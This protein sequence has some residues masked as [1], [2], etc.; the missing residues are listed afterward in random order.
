MNIRDIIKES[1]D[2][3]LNEYR[4][5]QRLPF[6][7]DKFKNKNYLE[8]YTDWL[9]DFGK[10]GKLSH[11]NLDFWDE[12]RKGVNYIYNHG[13]TDSISSYFEGKNEDELYEALVD[14]IFRSYVQFDE[15]GNVYVE[16]AIN[17]PNEPDDYDR[18]Y[19]DGEDPMDF[20]S[21]L[22][23]NYQN[24]V[25]GCWS[26]KNGAARAYCGKDTKNIIV[27]KGYIRTDDIDFIKTALLN[28]KYIDEFEIRVK[29]NAKV[30]VFEALY[31]YRYR[32][33][34]KGNLIVN[35]TYFGNK[36]TYYGE[37]APVDDG[38]G[39]NSTM[40]RK[41]NIRDIYEALQEQLSKGIPFDDIFSDI[42]PLD[43]D[44]FFGCFCQKYFRVDYNRNI[45]RGDSAFFDMVYGFSDRH[46]ALVYKASKGYSFINRKGELVNNGNFWFKDAEMSFEGC[47]LVMNNED[48]WSFVN[49][50][51]KLC[52]MWFKDIGNF[53]CGFAKVQRDDGKWSYVN[54]QGRLIGDGKLWFGEVEDFDDE[55]Y[56]LVAMGTWTDSPIYQ[57]D[58]KG[59]FYDY[60][61]GNLTSNPF[62]ESRNHLH[63]LITEILH[64]TITNYLTKN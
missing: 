31:N 49:K 9:E 30:E 32:L 17:V 53:S 60:G 13:L 63:N 1:I 23:D 55:G 3:L 22:A 41:G 2:K 61:T 64:Q 8:Q 28:A 5:E 43:D 16:R 19:I 35:A 21:F 24:N 42:V 14:Y 6:D 56:T 50:D 4:S 47:T 20:Y 7:D 40:D 57:M 26:Y 36:G 52:D 59:N 29:P 25:G 62:N 44:K 51:G 45:E 18:S 39:H 34:L 12:L 48:K 33:P 37:Y 15:N 38:F 11:S 54:N 46:V 10:Y 58:V 27:L